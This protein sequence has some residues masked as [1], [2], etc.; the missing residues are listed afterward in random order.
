MGTARKRFSD[1]EILRVV[2]EAESFDVGVEMGHGNGIS[3]QRISVWSKRYMEEVADLLQM[4]EENARLKRMV[5]SLN[6]DR[7]ILKDILAK[8]GKTR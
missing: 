8:V 2:R 3:R 6:L 4:R 1:A 7:Q 5:A